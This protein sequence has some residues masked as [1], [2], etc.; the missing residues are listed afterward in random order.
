MRIME[1]VSGAGV[2][3]AIVHCLELTRELARRGHELTL[4]CRP[5]AWIGEQLRPAGVEVIESELNSWPTGELKRI[6]RLIRERGTEVVHTHQSR[7][8]MFGVL[9]RCFAGVPSVA[10]AHNRLIQLHWMWNDHVIAVSNATR[11]FHRRF[12]FCASRR[13]DVIHCSVDG[14]RF[15]QPPAGARQEVRREFGL[16]DGQPLI[17]VIGSVIPRKGL[18]YLVDALPLILAADPQSRVMVVGYP[19]CNYAEQVRIRAE[20]L[21][22]AHAL[23]LTGERTDIDRLLPAFDIFALPSLEDQIPV[24]ILEAMASGLPVVATAVGGIPECIRDGVDGLLVPPAAPQPLARAII[25]L[26]NDKPRRDALGAAG[27]RRVTES[28]SPASKAR[29]VEVLFERVLQR[30]IAA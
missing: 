13:I 14:A 7:A 24:A 15:A 1:I 27:Q 19:D 29:E 28:F 11:D 23:I 20:K 16:L 10:T 4:V 30:R 17:G 21:G 25:S 12:N 6:G 9:L 22:V 26:L 8:N 5:Q 2:N 3:G 18:V